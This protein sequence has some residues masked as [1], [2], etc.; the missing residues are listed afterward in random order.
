LPAPG[1]RFAATVR[2]GGREREVAFT[3]FADAGAD[4]DAYRVWLGA[5]G[6]ALPPNPSLLA[7]GLESPSRVGGSSGEI[8]DS[9]PA[10]SARAATATRPLAQSGSCAGTPATPLRSP[11]VATLAGRPTFACAAACPA[12]A[13]PRRRRSPPADGPWSSPREPP[14]WPL[15]R[16]PA[17][18]GRPA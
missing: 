9:A 18:G 16:A 7:S 13:P 5:P 8:T 6:A 11:A 3:P 10:T 17:R 2:V 15:P 4:G 12:A 1:L 14:G